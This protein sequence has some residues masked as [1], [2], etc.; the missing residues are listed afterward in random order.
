MIEL[1]LTSSI[2][3]TKKESSLYKT[4]R[5]ECPDGVGTWSLPSLRVKIW[6]MVWA[7]RIH[8]NV[9][10]QPPSC[11]WKYE[12][13]IW[14]RDGPASITN[15]SITNMKHCLYIRLTQKPHDITCNA[16][17]NCH[18]SRKRLLGNGDTCN[19]HIADICDRPQGRFRRAGREIP[20]KDDRVQRR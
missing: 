15:N 18:P 11:N 6:Y 4:A 7:T 13:L 10:D 12:Q 9:Q 17:K 20:S 3:C 8:H 19:A 16:G 2:V 14:V 5:M 1:L